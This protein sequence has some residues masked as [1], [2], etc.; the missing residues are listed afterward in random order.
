MVSIIFHYSLEKRHEVLG[1][2]GPLLFDDGL[3][4]IDVAG[5]GIVDN[6]LESASQ[7]VHQWAQVQAEDRARSLLVTK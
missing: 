3:E 7:S 6:L 5:V 2:P 1:H 4:R